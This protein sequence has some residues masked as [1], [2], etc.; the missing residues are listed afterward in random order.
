[1]KKI[2]FINQTFG[3]G[4]AEQFGADLLANFQKQGYQVACY[5][6]HQPFAQLLKKNG[7]QQVQPIYTKL[8]I[9]GN[10]K[11]LLKAAFL[12]PK[13]WA[14]YAA[15]IHAN[16][17]ADVVLLSGFMEKCL[18]SGLA[19]Q[20]GLPVVWIEYGPLQSVFAKFWR[21]PFW[22]YQR[23]THIPKLVIVPTHN[24]AKHLSSSLPSLAKKMQI[25]PCGR[26]VPAVKTVRVDPNLVVCV[27]RMETGKGQDVLVAAFAEVV[28]K[29]PTA[30]LRLVGEGDFIFT[31]KNL[32]KKLHLEAHVE[33][34]DFVPD[35]LKPMREAAVCVFPSLWELE[36]FGLVTVEAMSLGKP[37][38]AFQ[39][40]PTPEIIVHNKTGILVKA[41][42]VT[43]LAEAILTFLKNKALQVRMG[44]AA[45]KTFLDKYTIDHI[46]IHYSTALEK[47][48]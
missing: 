43:A 23:V 33:F 48:L 37:V 10:W 42:D 6:T 5:V 19:Q 2:L 32:V 45:Q 40:G 26:P 14:E 9:I 21:L 11:G 39:A 27:S 16:S 17:D 3:M 1:M 36:G 47:V 29:I 41:G 35:A 15:I 44:Q 18:A 28:E 24:T 31:V 12:F 13:A 30:R 34:L 7:L 38:V 20:T 4:G 22:L 8:D 46:G 25:I